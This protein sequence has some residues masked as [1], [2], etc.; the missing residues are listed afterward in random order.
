[1]EKEIDERRPEQTAIS[2]AARLP[3]T[4][5]F[6]D[7][8]SSRPRTVSASLPARAVP[9]TTE[10]LGDGAS[11][12]SGYSS[13]R[14]Y[15]QRRPP[16]QGPR[17]TPSHILL[18]A[19]HCIGR[20][21]PF[22]GASPSLPPLKKEAGIKREIDSLSDRYY[23]QEAPRHYSPTYSS[24][25]GYSSAPS[26]G[27]SPEHSVYS[28][29]SSVYDM[30]SRTPF[31]PMVPPSVGPLDAPRYGAAPYERPNYIVPYGMDPDYPSHYMPESARPGYGVLGCDSSDVRNKRRRGNLPKPVTDILRAWFM[32]HLDHPYPSEEDKQM[33]ISRTGLSISQVSSRLAIS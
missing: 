14:H 18:F 28:R 27:H 5:T 32:D 31:P 25:N 10:S 13:D 24:R 2:Q 17:N 29:R 16:S 9:P 19:N 30:S 1:M 7:I 20:S 4:T 26:V 22:V 11:R 21:P 23:Y 3:A 6:E 12:Y 33:F 15:Q 8:A